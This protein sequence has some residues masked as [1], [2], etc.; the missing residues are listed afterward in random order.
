[1]NYDFTLNGWDSFVRADWQYESPTKAFD[2]PV[3]QALS[4]DLERQINLWN[5]SFGFVTESGLGVTFWGRNLFEDEFITTAFPVGGAARLDL[6]IPEPAAHL[7]RDRAQDLLTRRSRRMRAP[8]A[9]GR[10]RFSFRP[11]AP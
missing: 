8:L 4:R 6:G 7:W 11:C 1:M 9:H 5:A 10:G 2:N 3:D